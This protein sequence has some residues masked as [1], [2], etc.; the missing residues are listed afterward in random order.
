MKRKFTGLCLLTII[1]IQFSSCKVATLSHWYY[2]YGGKY[3]FTSDKYYKHDKHWK[4]G[5]DLYSYYRQ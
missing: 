1:A 2:Y 4:G 5:R 3:T